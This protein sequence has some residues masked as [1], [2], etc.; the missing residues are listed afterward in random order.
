VP[1][2]P[3]MN[4]KQRVSYKKARN[5]EQNAKLIKSKLKEM[6]ILRKAEKKKPNKKICCDSIL[7][8]KT[9]SLL[10]KFILC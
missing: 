5:N 4:K 10:T 8:I 3:G 1:I 6:I 7:Q 2:R 9:Y